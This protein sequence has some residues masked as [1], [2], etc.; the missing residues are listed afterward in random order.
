MLR[1]SKKIVVSPS[2]QIISRPAFSNVLY[3]KKDCS[4]YLNEG[5]H[6]CYAK[7][8][9]PKNFYM[10]DEIAYFNVSINNSKVSKICNISVH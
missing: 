3:F 6:V 2:P 9:V 10:G 7:I 8:T 4:P 5:K 1:A